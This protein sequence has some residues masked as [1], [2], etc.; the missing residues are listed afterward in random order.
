MS[1][2]IGAAKVLNVGAVDSE[3]RLV[4]VSV[5]SARGAPHSVEFPALLDTGADATICRSQSG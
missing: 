2:R 5:A 3:D 1:R 4:S